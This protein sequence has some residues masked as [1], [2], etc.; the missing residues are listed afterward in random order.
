MK[1][2][3]VLIVDDD[4][5]MG[6]MLEFRL[7]GL[8]YRTTYLNSGAKVLGEISE[9]QPDI[10]I[11]DIIM[12]QMDGYELHQKLRQNPRTAGIPFVFLSAKRET[13]DQLEG[14]R[15]G[16]DDYICKPFKLEHL[17][18][19]MEKVMERA[20]QAKSYSSADFSGNLKQM[21]LNDVMQI[22]EIN[23]KTGELELKDTTDKLIGCA[24]FQ[25]GR[26]I[27]ARMGLLEGE[28]AFLGLLG[29]EQG[30]FE[31]FGRPVD[32]PVKIKLDSMGL[33]LMA[34][35][36]IDESKTLSDHLSDY[37]SV[38]RLK[39]REIPLEV[40][41]QCG[42]EYLKVIIRMIVNKRTV[43]DILAS[44]VLSQ[45]RMASL[46]VELFDANLIEI[47][48]NNYQISTGN[49]AYQGIDDGLIK[50]LKHFS[51][52]GLEGWLEILDLPYQAGIHFKKG[53]IIHAYH[54]K[55]LAKKAF[56]R[57]FSEASGKF[58]FHPRKD[59]IEA[60][61]DAELETLLKTCNHEVI[62]LQALEDTLLNQII[63]IN[64][65]QKEDSEIDADM[66]Y[67]LPLAAQ[68]GRIQDI[69]DASPQTDYTT[70]GHILK[71]IKKGTLTSE[72][73][74]CFKIQIMIDSST[75]LPN[76]IMDA[77][78]ITV[79]PLEIIFGKK[80]YYDG[81]NIMPATCLEK[82]RQTKTELPIVKPAPVEEFNNI[83]EE[84]SVDRDILAILPSN[85]LMSV[86]TNA[87]NAKSKNF[88]TYL[89]HRDQKYQEGETL[90]LELVDTGLISLGCG[91]MVL[92]A[93]EKIKQNWPLERIKTLLTEL[94]PG[95]KLFF[96]VKSTRFLLNSKWISQKDYELF[97]NNQSNYM[98]TLEDG[99]VVYVERKNNSDGPA[100]LADLMT[101]AFEG[102][103]AMLGVM[104]ADESENAEKLSQMLT[105]QYKSCPVITTTI[106]ASIVS[107]LGPGALAVVCLPQINQG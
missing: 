7:S 91:L 82:M 66:K 23:Y 81:V 36:I 83:F 60:T 43:K 37:E 26:L 15:M 99:K 57:I 95:V 6:N 49:N 97:T 25:E 8:G 44:N 17:I 42:R 46:L 72:K 21:K 51:S 22:V 65:R 90:Q 75:D 34:T 39:T 69:I 67:I 27:N 100:G 45:V 9:I 77:P 14:L 40:E 58:K 103:P 5:I 61:I 50:V 4:P 79:M 87:A 86:Y 101:G 105:D 38:L 94:I 71:L 59:H 107:C 78:N 88:Y 84:I 10:V 74:H 63:Y 102:L 30:F 55:T 20:A 19:R 48:E 32:V 104:H 96:A 68:N 16:A 29:V 92:T 18:D 89:T 12:P 35:R 1:K 47:E 31:F 80:V 106:S 41:E 33:L 73:P 13:S 85:D 53:R 54:D 11:S 52:K 76:E 56:V 70:Y 3:K 93:L 2:I 64:S 28:E 24:F 98:F 62:A